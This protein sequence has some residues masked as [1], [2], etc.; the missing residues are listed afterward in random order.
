LRLGAFIHALALASSQLASEQPKFSALQS[1]VETL[2]K[3]RNYHGHG[4]SKRGII[5]LE[6][7]FNVPQIGEVIRDMLILECLAV[8][9]DQCPPL[10]EHERSRQDKSVEAALSTMLA[11]ED[12]SASR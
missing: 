4:R 12:Q 10:D 8:T 11:E 5:L 6:Q 2:S 3:V 9:I 1:A 7:F